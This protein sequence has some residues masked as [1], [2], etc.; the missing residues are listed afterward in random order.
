VGWI[1]PAKN[2]ERQAALIE[3]V[4]GP[5]MAAPAPGDPNQVTRARALF[6]G[7]RQLEEMVQLYRERAAA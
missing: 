6:D 2:T 4:L 7:E 5:W 3:T 1:E